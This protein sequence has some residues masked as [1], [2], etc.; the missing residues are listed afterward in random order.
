M[1]DDTSGTRGDVAVG[2]SGLGFAGRHQAKLLGRMDGVS[3]VAGADPDADARDEFADAVAA[4]VVAGHDDLL[5]EYGNALDAVVVA[6]PHGRHPAHVTAAADRGLDVLV[7]KPMAVSFTDGVEMVEH[8]ADAGVTL[9]VGYQRRHHPAFAELRRLLRDGWIGAPRMV[10]WQ[11]GQ[12]WATLNADTWRSDPAVAGG[13]ALY[14]T[15][16]HALESLFW[17]TGFG[18]RSVSGT[19]EHRDMDV[20]V[21]VALSVTFDRGGRPVPGTVSVCGESTVMYPDEVVTVWGT[22]GR[23]VLDRDGQ[24]PE[25]AERVRVVRGEQPGYVTAFDDGT[26]YGTL[27]TR[28]LERF[29][30]AVRGRRDPEPS[31][32]FC[33]RLVAFR[34]AA[35]RACRTDATVRARDLVADW[36]RDHPDSTVSE[37]ALIGGEEP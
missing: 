30:D 20:E 28:K 2:V 35:M 10:H 17:T 21:D 16:S 11:V 7:E 13:G 15:G 34:E 32:E 27:T 1:S 6:T 36:R 9:Q 4:P 18:L 12:C 8:C 31:G 14:D 23:V 26:D 37:D 33:L 22:D 5:A 3:V 24:H 29:V 19:M 25:S